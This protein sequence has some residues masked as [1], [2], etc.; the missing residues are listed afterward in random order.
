MPFT[1]DTRVRVPVSER[2]AFLLLLF[3]AASR[4]TFVA[5]FCS[6]TDDEEKKSNFVKVYGKYGD[7]TLIFFLTVNGIYLVTINGHLV[8]YHQLFRFFFF[9]ITAPAGSFRP[10][11]NTLSWAASDEEVTTAP[12]SG[13]LRGDTV[14]CPRLLSCSR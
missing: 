6:R 14:G 10:P 4:S 8:S 3:V 1:Q 5:R 13:P 9:L 11:I 2:F 7:H 12:L